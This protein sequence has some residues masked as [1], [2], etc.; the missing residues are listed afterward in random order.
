MAR[1][2]F[3]LTV[4]LALTACNTGQQTE[5][6]TTQANNQLIKDTADNQEIK[7]CRCEGLINAHYFGKIDI[8]DTLNGKIIRSI[9]QD[10]I[11]DTYFTFTIHQ[12]TLDFFKVDISSGMTDESCSGWIKKLYYIS[13]TLNNYDEPIVLYTDHSDISPVKHTIQQWNDD[14]F[15]ITKCFDNWVYISFQRDNNLYEGWLNPDK[16]CNNPYTTCN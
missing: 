14:Y 1:K 11:N 13:T 15:Q 2:F 5:Q 6:K 4:V 10:S 16:Q 7:Q 9:S 8:Y 12:D 3:I